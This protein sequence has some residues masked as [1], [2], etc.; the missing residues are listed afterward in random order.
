MTI[1]TLDDQSR[2][3]KKCE[4]CDRCGFEL[5]EQKRRER[6][7][8]TNGLTI[9]KDGLKRLIIIREESEE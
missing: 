2:Y 5:K 6:L 3:T 9:G 1:C 8:A 4:N 7:F